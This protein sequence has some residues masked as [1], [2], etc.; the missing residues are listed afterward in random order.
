MPA[1]GDYVYDVE[2]SEFGRHERVARVTHTDRG[3]TV[4]WLI[5]DDLIEAITYE[6]SP[7]GVLRTERRND[8]GDFQCKYEGPLLEFP[9]DQTAWRS[10][11]KCVKPDG[12]VINVVREGTVVRSGGESTF[13]VTEMNETFGVQLTNRQTVRFDSSTLLPADIFSRRSGSI[14]NGE[15]IHSVRLKNPS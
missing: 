14:R 2:H 11:A 12:T 9:S 15:T 6:S 1:P 4:H 7:A 3:Y 13:E 8:K 5:H 10:E